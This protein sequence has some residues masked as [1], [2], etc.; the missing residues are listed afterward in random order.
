MGSP[1]NTIQPCY[2]SL[3]S[4]ISQPPAQGQNAPLGFF[5]QFM[6]DAV[7]STGA[8][9]VQPENPVAA[10]AA[11]V[12]QVTAATTAASAPRTIQVQIDTNPG[13]LNGRPIAPEGCVETGQWAV[14][15][16]GSYFSAADVTA[17]G[18]ATLHAPPTGWQSTATGQTLEKL[19]GAVS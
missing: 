14:L 13:P 2:V 15:P 1:V 19:L 5:T 12:P 18:I 11:A 3:L 6:N 9:S 16:D 4:D 10:S 17:A 8:G 7:A